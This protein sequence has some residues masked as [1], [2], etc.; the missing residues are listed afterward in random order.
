MDV[1]IILAVAVAG[2][3]IM[4]SPRVPGTARPLRLWLDECGF[5]GVSPGVLALVLTVLALVVAGVVSVVVP[6]P[7][8]GPI[9]AVAGIAIP[10]AAL[11]AARTRRR[12][13]AEARWPD[14]IDSM[15]MALRAGAPLHESF[16]AASAQVPSEWS[17]SWGRAVSELARG[18]STDSVLL[19]FRAERAEPIADRVCESIAIASEVGGT[20]LP[21]VLEELARSV[22]DDVRLRRE[23]TSRQAWVRNAARLGS[24]APWVVV[25]MLG[26]RPENR[27]AFASAAGSALL[28]ACAGATVVAY[29]VMTAMGRLP[30]PPRWVRDE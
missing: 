14:I 22:R 24:C 6:I 4:V 19:S 28:I 26:S 21:R 2:I 16:A 7:V 15:R 10:I 18:A 13:V 23:A 9:A 27:E 25:V 20:E 12:A 3:A 5:S 11:D 1:A 30:E 29:V 8:L 17:G